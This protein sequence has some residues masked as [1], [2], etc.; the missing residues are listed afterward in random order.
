E[1]LYP[2]PREALLEE[3]ARFP[4]AEI[5]WCQEEP[6]NMGAWSFVDGRLEEVLLE[7]DGFS[8]RAQYIGRPEA[9]SP[10]TGSLGTHNAEQTLVLNQAMSN[11]KLSHKK[12]ISRGRQAAE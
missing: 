10:A 8:A 7:L 2:F 12:N 9:A 1:Q 11:I 3:L 6:K 5:V 4:E